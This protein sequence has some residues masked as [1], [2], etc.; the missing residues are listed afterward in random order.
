[1][2]SFLLPLCLVACVQATVSDSATLTNE[3]TEPVPPVPA[4]ISVPPTTIH[5]DFPVDISDA[6]KQVKNVGTPA[7]SITSNHMHSNTGDF[8][9]F[10]E[11]T[12]TA[13][14]SGQPDLQLV[15]VVLS[16]AQKASA[17]IDLPVLVDGS[18]LLA[19]FASGSVDLDFALTVAGQFPSG[20]TSIDLTSTIG[21]DVSLSVNKSVSDI[22]K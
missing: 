16:D 14:V 10:Q 20:L 6:I 5:K 11:L 7:L 22:G 9:F 4:G 2:K 12:I 18:Q 15:D 21:M 8:S 3:I 17:D 19:T 1:M 13:K